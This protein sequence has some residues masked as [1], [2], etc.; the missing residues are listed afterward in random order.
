M[1]ASYLGSRTGQTLALLTRSIFGVTGSGLVSLLLIGIAAGWAAFAFNLLAVIYDGLFSWGHVL[2][3]SVALAAAGIFNNLFGFTGIT[4]FARYIVAPLMIIWVL[5]LVLKGLAA[6]PGHVLASA[7]A[8]SAPLPFLSGVGVAIGSVMWGNE[9]DTWRYGRPK[10][11]WPALPYVIA[12]AIGL[13]LFVTGG[14]MMAQLSHAGPFDFGP[15]FRY[16]AQYSL[17]GALWLGAIV[18]TVLQVAINDGT[19]TRW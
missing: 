11:L 8:T 4:A 5:Y 16:T 1:P 12:L 18:A 15:A 14:W 3:I 13:V 9:P 19:T 6:I 17:F 10:F 2:V 7:P